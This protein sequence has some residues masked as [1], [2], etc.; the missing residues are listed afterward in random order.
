MGLVKVGRHRQFTD[1]ER[2][3]GAAAREHVMVSAWARRVLVRA[4]A[5]ERRNGGERW[6]RRAWTGHWSCPW[7]RGAVAVEPELGDIARAGRRGPL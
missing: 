7:A 5:A 1:S 4:A 3:E 2:V 6:G